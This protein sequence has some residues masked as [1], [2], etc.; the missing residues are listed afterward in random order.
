MA[1]SYPRCAGIL[2]QNVVAAPNR[3]P[4]WPWG[5]HRLVGSVLVELQRRYCE[6]AL[7]D[8]VRHMVPS[9]YSSR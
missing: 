6:Q 2:V 1:T 9:I 3:R 7:L 8:A 4:C 5:T